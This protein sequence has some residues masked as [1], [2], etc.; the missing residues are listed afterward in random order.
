MAVILFIIFG[1]ALMLV[2]ANSETVSVN[3]L[4]TQVP[5]MNTALLL[6]ICIVLGI[7]IGLLLG[8]QVFRVFQTRWE[9]A[10]LKKEIKKL[11]SEQVKHAAEAASIAATKK[12]DNVPPTTTTD[13]TDKTV[14]L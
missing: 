13:T 9:N 6:I 7:L 4:F 1:Y 2:L 12:V 5:E 8:L 3:L 11:R 14:N 10:R